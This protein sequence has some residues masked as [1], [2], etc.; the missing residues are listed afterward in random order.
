VLPMALLLAAIVIGYAVAFFALVRPR[1][2][3]S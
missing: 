3:E 1:L 2:L